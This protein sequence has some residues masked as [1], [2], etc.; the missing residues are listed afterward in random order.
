ME[1][2]RKVFI[3]LSFLLETWRQIPKSDLD[4]ALFFFG[5]KRM[6]VFP[7]NEAERKESAQQPTD[8]LDMDPELKQLILEKESRNEVCFLKPDVLGNPD[9][10][11]FGD[12]RKASSWLQSA[13]YNPLQLDP[14]WWEKESKVKDWKN[15]VRNFTVG[16]H[17]YKSVSLL[18]TASDS[19]LE[20]VL[21]YKNK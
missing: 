5:S 15:V 13:G 11:V 20:P 16:L 12:Y 19:R 8:Y 18:L 9:V 7:A 10:D 3:S 4:A 14:S 21:Q 6:W 2:E 17:D 1:G